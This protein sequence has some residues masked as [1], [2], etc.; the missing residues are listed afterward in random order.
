MKTIL[1]DAWNTFV[2]ETGVNHEMYELL[3]TFPNP[4]II[5]TN[6]NPD[7]QIRLGI[8]DMPYPVFSCNHNPDKINPLYYQKLLEKYEFQPEDVIYFEHNLAHVESAKS[9]RIKTYH[10]DKDAQDTSS[11]KKYLQDNL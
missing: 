6:A 11:L 8:V 10:Y 3:E 5:L 4:K 9:I 1:V 2:T 7:E